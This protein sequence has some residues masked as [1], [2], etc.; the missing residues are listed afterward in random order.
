MNG[1]QKERV[2]AMS[3][4]LK[5][6][7]RS[8][9]PIRFLALEW[10]E[11]WEF[12]HPSVLFEPVFCYSPNGT[13]LE[14][15]IE[16]AAIDIALDTEISEPITVGMHPSDRKEF[17]W[18]G[19]DANRLREQAEAAVRGESVK[20]GTGYVRAV[21]RWVAFQVGAN[22]EIDFEY[23]DSPAASASSPAPAN[24]GR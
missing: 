11:P 4:E 17:A 19:W 12:D 10:Q 16:D 2:S 14:S 5:S 15:L 8:G 13:A 6:A 21:E 18:R 20:L 3:E 1:M 24:A 9:R 22:G 7:V 23:I